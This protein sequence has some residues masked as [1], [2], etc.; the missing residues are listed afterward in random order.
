MKCT[1]CDEPELEHQDEH[2]GVCCDCYDV[3]WGAPRT[4]KLD[5]RTPV[6]QEDDEEYG[7]E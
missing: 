3:G 1:E 2:P 5:R 4:I 6:R 7:E